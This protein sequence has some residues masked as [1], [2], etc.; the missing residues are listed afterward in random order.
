MGRAEGR[1]KEVTLTEVV[2]SQTLRKQGTQGGL[3]WAACPRGAPLRTVLCEG[4]RWGKGTPDA[5]QGLGA[6]EDPLVF[7]PRHCAQLGVG[8]TSHLC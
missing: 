8:L 6:P 4:W 2:I 3:A 1:R 5:G 7:T